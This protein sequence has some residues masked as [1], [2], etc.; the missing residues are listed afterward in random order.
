MKNSKQK[1]TVGVPVYNEINFI[2]NTL[3][4]VVG[5]ADEIFISDN[6]STDG[7]SEICQ[8]FAESYAEIRYVRHDENKGSA[9]NFMYVLENAKNEYF[10]YLGGH[11]LLPNNHIKKLRNILDTEDV[12]LAYSNAVHLSVEYVLKSYYAYD[13][14]ES[15]LSDS[16][17][18]RI[19]SIIENLI[20][21]TMFMGL[22]KKYVLIKSMYDASHAK[23]HGIDHG[24]L[25]EIAYSGK[26]KLCNDT[27]YYRISP[28]KVEH[29]AYIN[30]TRVMRSIY[31]SQYHKDIHIPEL[32]PIGICFIHLRT[33]EKVASHAINKHEYINRV[34]E[35]LSR[36][37]GYNDLV[38][39]YL[40][41]NFHIRNIRKAKSSRAHQ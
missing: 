26:M 16:P 38:N 21:C 34:K 35:V 39:V 32:I 1:V 20:D 4:S 10:M 27:V 36:R 31:T 40:E 41:R 6:A 12:V 30:W 29:D 2:E 28:S 17:A 15:L 37:W 5:Q 11:D 9:F 3:R 33:A 24:I 7:T 25:G 19:L 8:K 14:A 13:Y 18:E 23:Y 22:H